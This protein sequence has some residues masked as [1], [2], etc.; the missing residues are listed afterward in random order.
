MEFQNRIR[1]IEKMLDEDPN[2]PFLHYARCLEYTSDS[3]F[4]GRPFWEK[5]LNQFPDYLPSY[6][7]AGVCFDNLGLKMMAIEIW[8][9]GVDEALKQQDFHALTELK[10][11][12]QNAL[13]EEDEN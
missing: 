9:K 4:A 13:L 12:L 5:I 7:Q 8:K 11:I 2:D 1:Q 6:Y 10:N 3:Y